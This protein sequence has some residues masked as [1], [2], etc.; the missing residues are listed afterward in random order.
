MS[1][2]LTGKDAQI[3][4]LVDSIVPADKLLSTACRW[5]LDIVECKKPWL[6]SLHRNDKIET[7]AEA[8]EILTSARIQAR[9]QS[10]NLRH[11]LVCIDVIEEGIV[12]GPRTGLWKVYIIFLFCFI[13]K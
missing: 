9:T 1:K 10:P 3:V 7:L 11:P 6:V 5:A 4:C 2:R 12:S 13:F 8:R